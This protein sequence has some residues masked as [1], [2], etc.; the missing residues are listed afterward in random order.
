MMN[1]LLEGVE[2]VP[3]ELSDDDKAQQS[4]FDA[5]LS[6]AIDA[7]GGKIGD[8]GL[9]ETEKDD[10]SDGIQTSELLFPIIDMAFEIMTPDWNVKV[11]EKKALAEA[12]GA[13][14]DKY[15]PDA[16]EYFGVEIT[17]LMTTGMVC[18]PRVVKKRKEKEINPKKEDEKTVKKAPTQTYESK[19]VLEMEGFQLD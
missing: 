5:I 16:G 8:T 17:A 3:A 11:K 13:L 12:Y 9:V 2:T 15:F 4:E 7:D 1:D 18:M 14:L 6:E 19:S 10:D